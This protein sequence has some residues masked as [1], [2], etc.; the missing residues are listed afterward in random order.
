[1]YVRLGEPVRAIAVLREAQRAFP[2]HFTIA[3]NLGTAW[4]LAGD[5]AQAAAALQQ[6]VHLAPGKL[7]QAEEYH[8]KLVRQR[9]KQ[10]KAVQELDDLFGV[11]YVGPKGEYE[12]GKLADDER[13]KLPPRAAAVLQQLALW[14]PADGRVLWQ[15]A[16]LAAAHGDVGSAAAMADGC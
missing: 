6:A 3:A 13:K 10:G 4:Q 15:L 8:L 9:L 1:L 5:L 14:L 16:E 11:R 2:N 12:P 7:L